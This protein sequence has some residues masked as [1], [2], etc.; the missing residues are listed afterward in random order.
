MAR[1]G[2]I[3][4]TLPLLIGCSPRSVP[5]LQFRPFTETAPSVT[6]SPGRA[7]DAAWDARRAVLAGAGGETVS[8]RFSIPEA[9]R[10]VPALSL[11][12]SLLDSTTGMVPASAVRA[13][14]M[15]P[16]R[17]PDWPG[18]H[19]KEVRPAERERYPLDALIP[20]DAP[21]GG[22]RGLDQQSREI[23]LWVEI[24]I[25]R[26][27]PPGLYSGRLDVSDGA[28]TL[29]TVPIDLLVHPFDLPAERE[30]E[31][32]ADVDAGLRRAGDAGAIPAAMRMLAEHGV[33]PVLMGIHPAVKLDVQRRLRVTWDEYDQT[34]EPYLDGHGFADGRP[35]AVWPMPFDELFPPR[36]ESG[37]IGSAA[38]ADVV[39]QYLRACAE[40]FEQRGWLDRAFVR[41]E[42]EDPTQP[43]QVQTFDLLSRL[44]RQADDRLEV[45]S[46]LFPQDPSTVG[47]ATLRQG[48]PRAWQVDVWMPRA[49][50]FDPQAMDGERAQGRRTWMRVDRPPFS[51]TLA[52]AG[53]GADA[54]AIPWQA[55][56]LH[57]AVVHLG[58]ANAWPAKHETADPSACAAFDASSLIYPGGAFGLSEPVPSVRLKMLQRGQQDMAYLRLLE[59]H[60]LSH[61]ADTLA[62][63]L[64]QRAGAEAYGAHL[65]DGRPSG[66]S[67]EP[68]LWETARAIM[69]AELTRKLGGGDP[70]PM[71]ADIQWRRFMQAARAVR[72]D[73]EGL[74]A[75][76]SSDPAAGR[77]E[78]EC[79]TRVEN[80]RRTPVAGLLSL[81]GLPAP[82]TALDP[83][84]VGP[85]PPETMQLLTLKGAGRGAAALADGAVDVQVRLHDVDEDRLMAE[86][87]ARLALLT[88][89]VLTTPITLDAD[90]SDW[91]VVEGNSAGDFLLI[92]AKRAVGSERD[93]ADRP[94][95]RTMV[96][97]ARDGA[98]LYVA[99]RC[100][101][102][103]SATD[104]PRGNAY[105]YDDLIP[106]GIDRVE[107]LFD[108]SC[109]GNRF[110]SD[111]YHLVLLRTGGHVAERGVPLG[112]SLAAARSWPVD[113]R[114]QMREKDGVW[115]IE[116]RIPLASLGVV[117]GGRAILG[118][119]VARFDEA[120]EEFST[121]SGA[122]GNAYDPI[123]L[124]TLIL[125]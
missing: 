95:R 84:H 55:R 83:R 46:T 67:G 78:L 4:A 86:T 108:A 43:A 90:L 119:N 56:R 101:V 80:H 85:V 65:A 107:L 121:W 25:P 51:G 82:W 64:V 93:A 17:V 115:V 92:S 106:R 14:R 98:N 39:R 72:I 68:A 21:Q 70:D 105:A 40:H 88:C 117:P 6:G 87:S 97:T 1:R 2:A 13:Y 18:W 10:G 29:G 120:E 42:G 116:T 15:H 79:L 54:R 69:T 124:G 33:A 52:L 89:G 48:D 19:L 100:E 27:S 118:F 113:V 20:V 58:V 74:R 50:F 76:P 45:L 7:A 23:H 28:R 3:F 5:T 16:V 38:F 9:P 125:P 63:S 41:I 32:M 36:P 112:E 109:D 81:E 94:R 53:S 114:W 66:W 24:A 96:F 91:P 103:R 104:Q 37:V 122:S 11:R 61:I 31:L 57:V 12:A 59:A 22:L 71:V 49:Q 75:K 60:E 8:F 62:A 30:V 73:V 26:G 110:P 123:T 99:L 111:L 77:L 47:S 44:C 35:A 102:A 34:V